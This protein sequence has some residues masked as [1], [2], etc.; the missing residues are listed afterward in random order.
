[1]W[2][3]TYLKYPLNSWK[4][5][6]FS[7]LV[8]IKHTL[9][10]KYTIFSA[11]RLTHRLVFFARTGSTRYQKTMWNKIGSDYISA[12]SM[13][14]NLYGFKKILKV[15][16]SS[17]EQLCWSWLGMHLGFSNVPEIYFPFLVDP[18][19]FCRSFKIGK[20]TTN[21]I[22]IGH[23]VLFINL[24]H[25]II[26]RNRFLGNMTTSRYKIRFWAQNRLNCKLWRIIRR[27][28]GFVVDVHCFLQNGKS[29]HFW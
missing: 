13:S 28:L 4:H 23:D 2:L 17:K 1:M 26:E 6:S 12:G 3:K 8:E 18:S 25:H 5:N 10:D 21:K 19:D 24:D 14:H 20:I 11:A 29:I 16:S 9:M 22:Y 27:I 7:I 15:C